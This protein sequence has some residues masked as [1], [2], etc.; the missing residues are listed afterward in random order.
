MAVVGLDQG[1]RQVHPSGDSGRGPDVAV[2]QVDRFGIYAEF[3]MPAPQLVAPAP[4]GRDLATSKATGL[5]EDE[6]AGAHAHD[7]SRVR[8]QTLGER[9]DHGLGAAAPGALTTHDDQR[10]EIVPGQGFRLGDGRLQG[11]PRR[12]GRGAWL[13]DDEAGD[14][15][16]GLADVR[17]LRGI[18]G[19]PE[20]PSLSQDLSGAG[21]VED[22]A[23]RRPEEQDAPRS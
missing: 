21:N 10:V 16:E 17:D 14:P 22:L 19:S 4:V 12:G 13:G 9:S 1:Q 11:Q 7:A 8:G 3:G 15:V 18:T 6:G 23:R 20:V 2:A 5:R